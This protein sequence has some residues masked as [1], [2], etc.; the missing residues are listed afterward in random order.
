ML[1]PAQNTMNI[2]ESTLSTASQ[3][4]PTRTQLLDRLA[5]VLASLGHAKLELV[6]AADNGD[7]GL[8][9]SAVFLVTRLRSESINLRSELE[10]HRSDHG[11]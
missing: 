10:R 9:D 1:Q 7:T 4:C 11:C 2:P 8:Y 5:N 6:T 3:V